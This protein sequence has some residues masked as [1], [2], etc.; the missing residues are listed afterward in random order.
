LPSSRAV[1]LRLPDALSG[2]NPR[3]LLDH[4]GLLGRRISDDTWSVWPKGD[5]HFVSCRDL[6]DESQL[7]NNFEPLREVPKPPISLDDQDV[8]GL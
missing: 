5:M 6:A 3:G 4:L 8:G 1:E 7:P 2:G